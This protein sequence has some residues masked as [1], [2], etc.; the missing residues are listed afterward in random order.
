MRKVLAAAVIVLCL[1]GGAW[2][3]PRLTVRKFE[4]TTDD[5][6]APAGA[7]MDMMVTELSK[8]GVFGLVEREAL[9]YIAEEQQL[10]MSGLMDMSTAPQV[11]RLKGAQYTMTGA[12]SLFYYEKKSTGIRIPL[13]GYATQKNTA[14]VM[15]EL[16]VIDNT[17]GEIV[18]AMNK[19]GTAKRGSKG[20]IPMGDVLLGA[21]TETEGGALASAARNAVEQHVQAMKGIEWKE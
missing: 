3:K 4:N 15:I 6:K 11:G 8:A 19:L 17:T 14:Y 5:E 9:N 7:I 10:A 13:I 21:R 1:A 18:Y 16:R 12:L 2:A 20:M